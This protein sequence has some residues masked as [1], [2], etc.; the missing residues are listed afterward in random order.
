MGLEDLIVK[1]GNIMTKTV[2][3]STVT[4]LSITSMGGTAEAI[5]DYG[6]LTSSFSASRVLKEKKSAKEENRKPKYLEETVSGMYFG[7]LA[8]PYIH[9]SYSFMNNNFAV[10]TIPEMISTEAINKNKIIERAFVNGVIYPGVSAA[11]GAPADHLATKRS[12]EGLSKSLK[13]I[14]QIMKGMYLS[15]P[16]MLFNVFLATPALHV[17][18]SAIIGF[19]VDYVGI[20]KQKKEKYSQKPEYQPQP[21]AA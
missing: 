14:P 13:A 6:V 19:I 21:A 10:K 2:I 3:L 17:P 15:V 11:Y 18:I 8:S 12:P 20:K 7:A 4:L 9:Y 1:A 5:R 16:L